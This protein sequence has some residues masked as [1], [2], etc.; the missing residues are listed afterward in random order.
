M[1][2]LS[3]AKQLLHY[4]DLAGSGERFGGQGATESGWIRL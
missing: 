3:M 1:V 4:L 2:W